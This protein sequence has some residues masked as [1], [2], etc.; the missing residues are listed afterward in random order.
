M[1][2]TKRVNTKVA[3]VSTVSTTEFDNMTTAPVQSAPVTSSIVSFDIN[4][5][6]ALAKLRELLGVKAPKQ[7]KAEK[8]AREP[9]C[10]IPSR[11]FLMF[12]ADGFNGITSAAAPPPAIFEIDR[13]SFDGSKYKGYYVAKGDWKRTS[14]NGA[15][16]AP[17]KAATDDQMR[18][19]GYEESLIAQV[20]AA[21]N[22]AKLRAA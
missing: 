13:S 22:A 3:P 9:S 16:Y 4:D 14:T 12:V 1:A 15:W 7:P 11:S 2:S 20:S 6:V 10:W 8:P 18:A 17:F 19:A 21:R 5:P